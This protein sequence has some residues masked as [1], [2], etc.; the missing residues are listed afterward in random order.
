M[1]FC[2]KK[3]RSGI[4]SKLIQNQTDDDYVP[5]LMWDSK[6]L[7][8]D[9]NYVTKNDPEPEDIQG[10]EQVAIIALHLFQEGAQVETDPAHCPAVT[11]MGSNTRHRLPGCTSN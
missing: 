8:W 9:D 6:D 5:A 2:H 10:G 1:T 3:I 11:T 7:R 4:A